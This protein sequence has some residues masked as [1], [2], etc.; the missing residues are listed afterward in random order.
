M[1]TTARPP[2]QRNLMNLSK[3]PF[4]L[5]TPPPGRRPGPTYCNTG[6]FTPLGKGGLNQ[7][8]QPDR[9]RGDTPLALDGPFRPPACQRQHPAGPRHLCRNHLRIR[10]RGPWTQTQR[11]GYRPKATST[12]SSL[13]VHHLI[14]HQKDY[15]PHHQLPL[16]HA[17]HFPHL[18]FCKRLRQSSQSRRRQHQQPAPHRDYRHQV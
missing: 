10:R 14:R 4:A 3:P 6:S 18:P 15:K 11:S 8:S 7:I 16:S 12:P 5:W 2:Q 17:D 13:L 9:S 1:L